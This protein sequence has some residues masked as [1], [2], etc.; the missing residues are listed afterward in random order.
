MG[1]S[2]RECVSVCVCVCVWCVCVCVCVC[3]CVCVRACVR[4]CVRVCACVRARARARVS[5]PLHR[6]RTAAAAEPSRTETGRAEARPDKRQEKVQMTV[7]N[8]TVLNLRSGGKT[9][10]PALEAGSRTEGQLRTRSR[11]ITPLSSIL[12]HV[13]CCL[14]DQQREWNSG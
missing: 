10:T 2:E 5:W 4:A 13:H 3:A 12:H 7:S 9:V 14:Q 6:H 11:L 1:E 8:Y